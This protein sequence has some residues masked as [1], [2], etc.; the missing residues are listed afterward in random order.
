[1]PK[2]KELKGKTFGRLVVVGFEGRGDYNKLIWLCRCI[3]GN[4]TRV[5][6]DNLNNGRTKSCGCLRKTTRLTHG[7]CKTKAYR[8][9]KKMRDRCFNP[10]DTYYHNYGGRGINVC[11][12]WNDFQNFFDDMG[13]RPENRS[14]DRINNDG[15]YEPANCRWATKDQQEKNKRSNKRIVFEG[16]SMIGVEWA[17][18]L[19]MDYSTLLTRLRRGW[20][21]ERAFTTP[22]KTKEI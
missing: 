21:V 5:L 11:D 16:K 20:T 3:C 15:D 6:A 13:E 7:K 14:L 10:N 22:V 9:W 19:N 18:E 8:S 12:R 4:E 17:K 1:M 2:R